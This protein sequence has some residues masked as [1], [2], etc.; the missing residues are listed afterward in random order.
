MENT[1]RFL[2]WFFKDNCNKINLPFYLVIENYLFISND[3]TICYQKSVM[4]I[5]YH[6]WLTCMNCITSIKALFIY[7]YLFP[8]VMSDSLSCSFTSI[9]FL[10]DWFVMSTPHTNT[11]LASKLSLLYSMMRF[12]KNMQNK[13]EIL[14]IIWRAVLAL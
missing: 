11:I 1:D 12:A 9:S 2:V 10:T 3:P 13:F 4:D 7:S 14:I 6:L 5:W 8:S